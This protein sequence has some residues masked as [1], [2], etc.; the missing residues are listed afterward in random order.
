MIR[1]ISAKAA[2]AV[3]DAAELVK[4]PT[5]AE[6]RTWHVVSGKQLLVIVEP[7]YGGTSRNGRNGWTWRLPGGGGGRQHPESTRDRA[8]VQG[9]A[10]WQR[11]AITRPSR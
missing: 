4:A 10:A 11:A 5:W 8:A 2:R 9:L 6:T 3:I 7:S 1:R